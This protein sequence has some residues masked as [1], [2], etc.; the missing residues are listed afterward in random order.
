MILALGLAGVVF[1]RYHRERVEVR[2][3]DVLTQQQRTPNDVRK[4]KEEL[5]AMDLSRQELERELEGRMQFVQSLK[6]ENFYLGVD[7]QAKK[8]RFYY[9]DTVLREGDITVGEQKTIEGPEG[10]T[11]TFVPVKGSFSVEGKAVNHSWK[12]PEWVYAMNKQPAPRSPETIEG[13]LG[14]YVLFLPD[15]Y[16]I[17]TPPSG[18]SPLQGPKP[19]SIMVSEDDLRA[20]WPRI[21]KDKTQVYIF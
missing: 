20:I 1:A 13:G 16:V 5:A 6:S 18:S 2:F 7:T 15:G 9:G 4:I 19:G 3:A 10:K 17:H 21:H 11:W 8:L 14:R 12:V